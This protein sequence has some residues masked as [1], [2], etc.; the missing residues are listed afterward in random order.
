VEVRPRRANP[1]WSV[2]LGF[3]LATVA[4]VGGTAAAPVGTG[5][6]RAGSEDGPA[7]AG[8][9]AKASSLLMPLSGPTGSLSAGATLSFTYEFEIVHYSPAVG[10]LAVYLPRLFASFP[11][12]DGSQLSLSVA[13]QRMVVAN[14]SWTGAGPGTASRALSSTTNFASGGTAHLSSELIAVMATTTQYEGLNLSF[15][16][17]WATTEGATHQA[18][19]WALNTVEQGCPSDFWP[20]PYVDLVRDWGLQAPAG[21]NFTA[22]V[23]GFTSQ[24]YFF[25]ELETPSGTVVY[26]HAQTTAPGNSTAQDVTIAYDCWCGHLSPGAYLVH[27]HNVMGALLYSISVTVT[28]RDGLAVTVSGQPASGPVPLNVSFLARVTP[29]APPYSYAWNFGDGGTG[30]AAA[31]SHTYTAAGSFP[32]TLTVVDANGASASSGVTVRVT[33]TGSS[34]KVQVSSNVSGGPV[35]LWVGFSASA[36]GGTAP[37]VVSWNFDDGGQSSTAVAS[38]LYVRAGN[39]SVV[40]T[41]RDATGASANGSLA[42]SVTS[43]LKVRLSATPASPHPG[44][45]VSIVASV[46]GNVSVS[47]YRWTLNGT[48]V[49]DSS[50]QLDFGPVVAGTYTV[51]VSVRDR[52]G[53]AGASSMVLVISNSSPAGAPLTTT[54][55]HVVPPWG[56]VPIAGGVGAAVVVLAVNRS[57]RRTVTPPAS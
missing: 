7:A 20:A 57:R 9:C 8:H 31:P 11:L 5:V 48:L 18:S 45:R 47:G 12:S 28:S 43:G 37:Y 44:D 19:W 13:P 55:L 46:Q 56:W 42:V 10:R 17:S 4:I 2:L 25:L 51:S 16:W 14:G 49:H 1:S 41:A 21:S 54:L 15:R 40:A 30:A 26:S 38:H 27:I 50:P 34:M 6:S 33:A 23:S 22:A 24:Q 3:V 29:G 53:A 36:E 35:P 39:Y 52:A 32:A